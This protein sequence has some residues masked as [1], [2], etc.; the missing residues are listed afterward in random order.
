MNRSHTLFTFG[1]LAVESCSRRPQRFQPCIVLLL[2]GLSNDY[3]S[4]TSNHTVSL[5]RSH[6]CATAHMQNRSDLPE[7][8]A[9]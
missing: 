6:S 1:N 4:D 3:S 9:S 5:K 8:E 2:C 7:K